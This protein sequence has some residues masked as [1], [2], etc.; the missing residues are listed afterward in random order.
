MCE[1]ENAQCENKELRLSSEGKC[2]TE[3]DDGGD[4]KNVKISVAAVAGGKGIL[5]ITYIKNL[6]NCTP[7]NSPNNLAFARS[8]QLSQSL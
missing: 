4:K 6:F 1:L 7:N 3:S 8:C 5:K 2:P